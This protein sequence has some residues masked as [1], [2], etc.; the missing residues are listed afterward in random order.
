IHAGNLRRTSLPWSYVFGSASRG[1][2][3]GLCDSTTHRC[4]VRPLVFN[5]LSRLCA[6]FLSR[7]RSPPKIVAWSR[8]V[9]D[10]IT[11]A[12][13]EARTLLYQAAVQSLDSFH[14]TPA[15]EVVPQRPQDKGGLVFLNWQ[16]HLVPGRRLACAG[17]AGTG[18]VAAF[19]RRAGTHPG[20]PG[21]AELSVGGVLVQEVAL[22]GQ[23]IGAE[24]VETQGRL[25][26]ASQV[27]RTS[28]QGSV[29]G[30]AIGVGVTGKTQD[31]AVH[32][33][34]YRP[35]LVDVRA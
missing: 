23:S 6:D 17:R 13:E 35:A 21:R 15:L 2:Q 1:L 25:L 34:N 8:Q 11:V 5:L 33:R 7:E 24:L 20:V 4:F 18:A 12:G 28:R 26:I 9:R 32:G 16:L 22:G 29:A 14:V 10:R 27:E 3:G 30:P 31:V 19:A